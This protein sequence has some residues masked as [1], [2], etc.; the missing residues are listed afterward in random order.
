LRELLIT[1]PLDRIY[2]TP[3]LPTSQVL[4]QVFPSC[5]RA[6]DEKQG[7]T[8]PCFQVFFLRSFHGRKHAKYVLS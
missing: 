2:E 1:V 7:Q 8:V 4:K 6:S 3:D 5:K